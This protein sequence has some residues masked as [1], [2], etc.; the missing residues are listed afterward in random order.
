MSNYLS[1]EQIQILKDN[2]TSEKFIDFMCKFENQNINNDF[3]ETGYTRALK[4]I[5]LIKNHY[6]FG[7]ITYTYK[8]SFYSRISSIHHGEQVL[9]GGVIR[10]DNDYCYI[11]L[12]NGKIYGFGNIQF[13]N[14][15]TIYEANQ[16]LDNL[17][18]QHQTLSINS[19]SNKIIK[20]NEEQV[21]YLPILQEF[22]E[23][24]INFKAMPIDYNVNKNF[25]SNPFQKTTTEYSDKTKYNGHVNKPCSYFK[26]KNGCFKKENCRYLHE[27]N[28]IVLPNGNHKFI[29]E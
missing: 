24:N 7:E 4:W 11:N 9:F 17:A 8:T 26:S 15:K 18:I 5:G 21:E 19:I 27:G 14:I 10:T 2:L 13:P 3:L 16:L 20:N 22:D 12:S 28:F 29:A 1:K 23:N 25:I 6:Y